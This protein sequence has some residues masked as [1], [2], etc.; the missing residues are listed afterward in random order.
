MTK[1][2]RPHARTLT[3]LAAMLAVALTLPGCMTGTSPATGRT[4][5]TPVSVQQENQLGREEHPK[6]MAEFGGAYKEIPSLN[7]YVSQVGNRLATV[8][9]RPNLKYTF[10]LLNSPDV[11]AFAL[12]GGYVYITRGLLALADNEAEMAGVLGHETGH[13]NARHTAERMGHAQE[14]TILG[15][16]GVLASG[17]LF[18]EQG[19]QVAGG[20][21]QQGAAMYL[22]HYSQEQEFEADSLGVRYLKGA[23]YDPQ[24]MST[25]LAS[26]REQTQLELQLAGE[27]PT[28]ADRSSMTA[29]HPRTVDRVQRAIG[30]AGPVQGQPIINRDQYLAQIDGMMFGEDPEQGVTRGRN[31]VHPSLRFAFDVPRGFRI[32][33]QP[34]MVAITGPQGT[35][36]Q[37]SL[38]R[39]Q[40][41]PAGVLQR[42]RVA[43]SGIERL[44]IN[45]MDAATGLARANVRGTPVNVRSVVIRHNSG[46]LYQF[47]FLSQADMGPRYDNE[48]RDIA[49][50]FRTI[51]A[52][53]A[54]QYRPMRIRIVTVAPGD[55]IASLSRQ[56]VVAKGKEAWFRVLNGLNEGNRLQAG[57]KVK[58]VAY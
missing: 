53:E 51:T 23:Q 17:I 35:F 47:D 28:L 49:Y 50:S 34:D 40:G 25:F 56:M 43:Y 7:A 36:S 38:A 31:F 11:N 57:Q 29:S 27:D 45:G 14:A 26:L 3:S 6:I 55:T 9:E 13:V 44:T 46:K 21:A 52:Q 37:L 2:T 10:T 19:A 30:E 4:F 32:R 18:G 42:G 12:P 33:N 15:T 16:L 1:T 8:G 54:S 39:G 41:D 48:F 22:G 5:S 20:L 58:I 24:A